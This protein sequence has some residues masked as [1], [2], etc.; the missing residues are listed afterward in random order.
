[1]VVP[2]ELLTVP[3]EVDLAEVVLVEFYQETPALS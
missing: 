2:V 1:V 3:A